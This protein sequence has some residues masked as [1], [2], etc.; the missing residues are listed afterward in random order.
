MTA[1]EQGSEL[2]SSIEP[3][4]RTGLALLFLPRSGHN[5][6]PVEQAQEGQPGN[7]TALVLGLHAGRDGQADEMGER[8]L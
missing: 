6:S 4:R 1:D 5:P 8:L 2:L 3:Q 7:S